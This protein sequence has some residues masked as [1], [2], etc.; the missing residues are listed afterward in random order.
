MTRRLL[1]GVVVAIAALAAFAASPV[2]AHEPGTT[3]IELEIGATAVAGVFDLPLDALQAA[4]G[5]TLPTDP[6]GLSGVR[7]A[8]SGYVAHHLEVRSGDDVWSESFGRLT[9]VT[10]GGFESLR[11]EVTLEPVAAKTTNTSDF[12]FSYDGLVE[13]DDSQVV[14]VTV[15]DEEGIASLQGVLDD[16]TTSLDV[17]AATGDDMVATIRTM[18]VEGFDHVLD[19]A[20]HMLFLL[21]LLVP[22]PLVA[23]RGRW[24]RADGGWRA[25]RRVAHVATAFMIG[26]SLT[27][28]ISAQGWLTLPK[29][30]I[31]VLIGV[32]VAVSAVHAMRPLVARGEV[33]IAGTFGLVHG[34]AFAGILDSLEL[35]SSALPSLLGFNLGI[36][37]AQLVIIGLTFP[38]IYLLSRG[39][40]FPA[41]R[42]VIAGAAFAAATGWVVERLGLA[43]SPFGTVERIAVDHLAWVV[44]VLGVCSLVSLMLPTTRDASVPELRE[45]QNAHDAVLMETAD[46]S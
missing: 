25:L 43:D 13:H 29:S 2:S 3:G 41:V 15:V 5:V 9:S 40:L 7:S 39:P 20:D 35:R 17:G 4:L 21:V 38:S 33:L 23:G 30:T 8:V 14:F 26:H 44:V 42:I 27:L 24:Q 11:L 28:V 32:S 16:D 1:V 18:A 37:A 10:I 19:G 31:E 36:E 34:L 45:L 6:V 22:A 46:V 12:T